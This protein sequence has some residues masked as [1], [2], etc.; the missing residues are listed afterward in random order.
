MAIR[1]QCI[2]MNISRSFLPKEIKLL[3]KHERWRSVAKIMELSHRARLR[4][5]WIIY[6]VTGHTVQETCHHYGIPRKT[7]YKWFNQ[8][9]EDNIYSLRKLEDK[10]CAPKHVRQMEITSCEEGRIVALRKAYL[11][12]GKMKLAKIYQNTYGEAISSWKIQYTI[13]KYHL[14][15]NPAKVAKTSRKRRDGV[16]KK[17]ITELKLSWYQKHAGV[18]IC[19]DTIVLHLAG[20]K[21]YIFTA[22]DKFGK[23]AFARM[24]KNRSS[25][26][27]KDFLH[28]LY[29]LLDGK[30][31]RVGHD[32]G[33][34]FEKYFRSTC[35]SLGIQQYYSRPRTP[36]DNPDNERFNQTFETEFL[37]MGNFNSN[38]DIFNKK[39]TE[40]LI[41]YNF[42]RPH[43]TLGY[44]T[45]LELTKVSPMWC[46][47]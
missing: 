17:R 37:N 25:Y 2:S 16:K 27:G 19:L 32:N 28:R 12:Y 35:L 23:V 31:T 1:Y 6:G 30:I 45:P 15:H 3:D 40:W 22:I 21:R 11:C 42:H 38:T 24:Y 4:L 43:E 47:P 33:S 18:L 44:R 39:F 34:E 7:F 41:E 5:E 20:C 29:F 26:N 9:D 13:K 10:S 8:F 36:K 46:W 14:Y